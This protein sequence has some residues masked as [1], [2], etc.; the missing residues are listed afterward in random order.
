MAD[1]DQEQELI[2]ELDVEQFAKEHPADCGKPHAKVYIIRVDRETFR[3]PHSE[4]T[5]KE[6]LRLVGK[7]P[8]THKLFQK[9]KGGETKEIKPEDIV[10]FVRPGVERFMTIPCDTTEGAGG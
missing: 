10:N 8:Q 7:T 2:D 5:G 6:I 1:S 9:F 4:L 3:V